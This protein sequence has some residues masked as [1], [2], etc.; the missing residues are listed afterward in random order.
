MIDGEELRPAKWSD[1]PGLLPAVLAA[2]DRPDRIQVV[3]ERRERGGE[4][5]VSWGVRATFPDLV[6]TVTVRVPHPANWPAAVVK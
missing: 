6:V 4:V 2:I 5:P 1:V 3:E